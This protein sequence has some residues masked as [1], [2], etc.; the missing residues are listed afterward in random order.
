M[1]GTTAPTNNHTNGI[2]AN[3]N[4]LASSTPTTPLAPIT[5]VF[6]IE[7]I[8]VS[9]FIDPLNDTNLSNFDWYLLRKMLLVVALYL[10]VGVLFYCHVESWS[11]LDA[12]YFCLATATTVGMGDL[13]P[14]TAGSRIFTIFFIIVGIGML[15]IALGIGGGLLL[16]RQEQAIYH[17]LLA[18][19]EAMS[20][21]DAGL[22]PKKAWLGHTTK[23]LLTA[24]VQFAF[25][26][27]S[28][29]IGFWQLEDSLSFLDAVYLCVVT[30]VSRTRAQCNGNPFMPVLPGKGF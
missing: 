19:R 20:A 25:V 26:I 8:S 17:A 6:S 5:G 24:F 21:K 22:P 16:E 13:V 29:A 2:H 23:R 18:E 12:V 15:A 11:I 9:G 28:G 3:T 1:R 27:V 10:F 14:T 7:V 4:H 30:M